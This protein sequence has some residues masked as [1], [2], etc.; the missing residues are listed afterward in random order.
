MKKNHTLAV[1]SKVDRDWEAESDANRLADAEAIK[2]D[3][4]RLGRARSAA[5][6][7]LA[8]QEARTEG[9]KRIADDGGK[10]Q[11]SGK[12]YGKSTANPL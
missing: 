10:R 2:A 6:S 11:S 3:P 5:K 9:L 8:E 7:M 12:P 1:P 4:T